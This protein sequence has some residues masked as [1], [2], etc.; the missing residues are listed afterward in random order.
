MKIS[1]KAQTSADF[2]EK[3]IDWRFKL[4]LSKDEII[5]LQLF[6]YRLFT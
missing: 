4:I 2:Q 3:P 5:F 6:N 1:R